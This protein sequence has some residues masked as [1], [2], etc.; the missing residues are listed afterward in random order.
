[1]TMKY[2][3]V[4]VLLS[5]TAFAFV[6]QKMRDQIYKTRKPQHLKALKG[7]AMDGGG[8]GANFPESGAAWFYQDKKEGYISVCIKRDPAFKATYQEGV[9]AIEFAFKTW[10]KYIQDIR[11]YEDYEEDEDGNSIPYPEKLKILT[12]IQIEQNCTKDT[13]LTFYLGLVDK[14]VQGILDNMVDPKA[15][16]YR[17]YSDIDSINGTSKGIIYVFIPKQ[18][19]NGDMNDVIYYDWSKKNRLKTIV[20]HEVG[21]VM[22]IDHVPSTIMRDNLDSVMMMASS[23]EHNPKPE[24]QHWFDY[25]TQI[26]HSNRVTSSKIYSITKGSLGIPGS[27]E[28]KLTF[29]FFMQR[30]LVGKSKVEISASFQAPNKIDFTISDEKGSKTFKN[31]NFTSNNLMSFS[32]VPRNILKRVRK[33]WDPNWNFYDYETL[34]NDNPAVMLD[35]NMNFGKFNLLVQMNMG[36][37]TISGDILTNGQI[38][39][40][41]LTLFYYH[42]ILQKRMML[43]IESVGNL[44]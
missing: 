7:G 24:T 35:M 22:G 39:N 20:L 30:E 25:L 40:N 13:D 23:H 2:L 29:K 26:D 21:H 12:K 31:I 18:K 19:P 14:K 3:V 33:T 42:P 34:N 6:P 43:M 28:E 16:A 17:N 11:L 8:S 5:Q 37:T 38:I 9:E 27:P 1:M 36:L 4:L 32:S 15:F 41:P 44:F 10:E